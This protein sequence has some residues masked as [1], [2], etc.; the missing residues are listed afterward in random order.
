MEQHAVFC[1]HAAFPHACVAPC[2][3]QGGVACLLVL[4][5]LGR[6][7]V[8][9]FFLLGVPIPCVGHVSFFG[10]HARHEGD[11]RSGKPP[12]IQRVV[13][14]GYSR[15]SYRGHALTDLV[16]DN[17]SQSSIERTQSIWG[18]SCSVT[19]QSR[20]TGP[21]KLASPLRRRDIRSR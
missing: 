19:A 20:L 6:W 12:L 21:F 15:T 5:S 16:P 14:L 8:V 9:L 18:V 11:V 4:K 13:L 10:R 2:T 17:T 1:Q 7:A 3:S